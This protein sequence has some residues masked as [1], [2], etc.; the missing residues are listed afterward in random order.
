MILGI[1]AIAV[2]AAPAVAANTLEMTCT[3]TKYVHEIASFDSYPNGRMTVSRERL[4]FD[5]AACKASSNTI[6]IDLDAATIV[7]TAEDGHYAFHGFLKSPQPAKI[8]STAV[9]A[10]VEN[11]SEIWTL[12]IDRK[13]GRYKHE[14]RMTKEKEPFL[15]AVEGMCVATAPQN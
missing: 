8:S 2:M 11:T 9:T 1:A 4:P 13:S 6:L 5:A 3:C 14:L 7:S 10:T 12:K 15:I